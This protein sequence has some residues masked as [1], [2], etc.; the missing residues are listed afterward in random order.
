MSLN[1]IRFSGDGTSMNRSEKTGHI[2]TK[3]G[4]LYSLDWTAGLDY[5]LNCILQFMLS[6]KVVSLKIN[7]HI[8]QNVGGVKLW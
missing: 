4:S 5:I 8:A 6:I 7:Y 3:H 1:I 2:C